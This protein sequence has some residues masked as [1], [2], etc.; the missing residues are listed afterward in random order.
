MTITEMVV[1]NVTG[2]EVSVIEMTIV[3]VAY[4]KKGV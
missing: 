4:T 3:G 2:V 1:V